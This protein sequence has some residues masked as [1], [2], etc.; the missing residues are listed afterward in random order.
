MGEV[1]G[2][3]SKL[4]MLGMGLMKVAG[5]GVAV[6]VFLLT[7]AGKVRLANRSKENPN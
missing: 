1:E 2:T 3:T 6:P 7:Q 4:E 5:E